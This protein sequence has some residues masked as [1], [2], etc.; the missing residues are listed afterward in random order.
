MRTGPQAGKLLTNYIY[1]PPGQPEQVSAPQSVTVPAVAEL[2]YGYTPEA[3][4]MAGGRVLSIDGY[5]RTTAVTDAFLVTTSAP[6][7]ELAIAFDVIAQYEFRQER[8]QV[9]T[10]FLQ[11]GAVN[12]YQLLSFTPDASVAPTLISD[13]AGQLYLTW[14]ERGELGGFRIY[15]ASTA[16]DMVQAMSDVTWGDVTRVSRETAFGLLSGAVLS[17]VLVALWLLL[18][19]V[20]LYLTS[21]LRRGQPGKRVMAGTIISILLAGAVYWAAKLITIPGIR[22]YVP[23]SAWVPGIP[24]WLQAPLQIGVPI[25]TTLVGIV[26]AWYF[27]YRRDSESILNF[28]LVFA[29]VDGLLTMAVYGF[30]FYNVI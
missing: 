4:L 17:P 9:G 2:D 30:Q 27:T 18:P 23:F 16:P 21:I 11:N 26:V 19:M 1:F 29:A 25:L 14:L 13:E 22:S 6:T 15:F 7:P 20:V 24:L 8:G 5:P 10:L 3:G 28:L 12:G